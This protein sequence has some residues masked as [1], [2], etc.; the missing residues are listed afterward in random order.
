LEEGKLVI[1]ERDV[2]EL[3]LSRATDYG[4]R[5]GCPA[6]RARHGYCPPAFEGMIDWVEAVFFRYL[7]SDRS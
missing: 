4:V 7:N 5:L 1:M 2:A 3:D 6:L